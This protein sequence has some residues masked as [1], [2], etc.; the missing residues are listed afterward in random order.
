LKFIKTPLREGSVFQ[1]HP[2]SSF[3]QETRRV[4]KTLGTYLAIILAAFAFNLYRLHAQK[5]DDESDESETAMSEKPFFSLTTVRSYSRT[6]QARLWASYKGISALD[7]RVYRVS[8]PVKFFQQ[9]DDPHQVGEAEKDEVESDYRRGFSTLE[10]TRSVKS[11]IYAAVKEYVRDQLKRQHRETFNKK[12]RQD[13]TPQRTPLNVADY[14]RVPLLNPSQLV[15]SWR[16]KL[17]TV[18]SGYDARSISLGRREPGVYLVEGVSGDLRAYCVAIVTELAMVQ[19]TTTDGEVLTYI[20]DRQTGAPREGAH[21]LLTRQREILAK[22]LTDQGGIFKT[23]VERK[24]PEEQ[25]SQQQVETEENDT[26]ENSYL[27]MASDHDSFV[28]SDLDSFYFGAYGDGYDQSLSGYIYT[29]RPVYRPEQKV[30]FKGILRRWANQRYELV[31]G[32]SVKVTIDDYQGGKLSEQTLAL[33]SRGTFSG[34]LD[35]PAEAPLGTYH[36]SAQVGSGETTS[37]YFSVQEYKKP[38]YKVRVT[39][40]KQ[41]ASVGERVRFTID[42]RYFFG[43][44]VADADVKYYIH[45]S[46]YYNYWWGERD[47][48]DEEEDDSE[49]MDDE[50]YG[51]DESYYYGIGGDMVDEG[52]GKLDDKGRMTV[53]FEV[54][55]PDETDE[56]DYTYRLEAQV[57]DASR[58][59]MQASASFTGT[60]G[61][62]IAYAQ[63][64][65]YIYY[66]NDQAR[67]KIRTADYLGHPV[68]ARVTLK[69]IEHRW[70]KVEK[71]NGYGST[72]TDYEARERELSSADIETGAQGMADYD[73]AVPLTGNIYI[74]TILHEE[75]KEVANRGGSFW[76]TDR[77]GEWSELFFRDYGESSI[78]L[79]PDKKSYR[80]GETAHVLAVLP[81][82]GV[83]LLVTTE[84]A[85]VMTA[86]QLDA[87]GRTLLIDVPIESI[88]E[89]NV[90]LCVA[91]VK[92]DELYMDDQRLS[93]PARDKYL[94]L[95]II[96]NKKEYK[97]R[98]TASY[99]ILARNADGSA[100]QGAEVSLGVVDEAIYS[101]MAEN[102]GSIRQEFY[103]RR[104]KSVETSLSRTFLF[105][106]YSGKEAINLASNRS[107]YQLADF[108][109]E[110]TLTEPTVRREFK[111]TAFWQPDVVTGA[112]GR[113]TVKFK[114][115]DNLTTWR[116]TARA[117]TADTRVGSAVA[118]VVARKDVI[119]RLEM[120]RFLTEGD[121]VIISGVVHN[122]LKTQKTTRISLE[123][124]GAQLLD[125]K[126]QTVTIPAMGQHRVDW[127]VAARAAGEMSLLAKALTDTESDAVEMTME[128]V[129]HGLKQTMGQATTITEDMSEQTITLDLPA[130]PDVEARKL[131]IEASPS[132]A[133]T[134]F[135]ALDYLT[136]YPYGCVEQTMSRFLPDVIV[137]Q[138]LREVQTA[139]ITKTNNLD[140]KVQ[141]GLERLY[142][143]Q[144][145]DGGWGWWK[146]DESDPF[147]TAYVIDGLTLASRAGYKTETWRVEG[148]RERLRRLI[149]EG[150]TGRGDRLPDTETRA[151]MIYAL[152][153]SG[154]TDSG[155]VDE[156]YGTRENL[157]AYGR[158]LLALAL[159]ERGD[160]R[161]REV[162]AE[163]E[164]LARTNDFEAHW[165]TSFKTHYGYERV[166]DTEAT[167]LSLKALARITPE[168]PLLAKAARW[169][170]GNRRHGYYWLST[171]ETAFAIFG[172]TEYLKVSRELEPDYMLE[173]YVNDEPVI[174]RHITS[175]D[176]RT[177]QTFTVE[178]KGRAVGSTNRVRIVKRGRGALYLSS[179]LEYF[180]GDEE[181]AAQSSNDLKLTREYL[182]L[183]VT[184]NGNG[185][186]GWKLEPLSGEVRSGDLIVSR[187]RVEGARAQYLMV[188]DP[189]PAGC[190]QIA[191][192]SGINL[193]YVDGHWS[194]WYSA[195]EFRDARTV[196][197]L[198]YFD[199]DTTFQYA[200]RVEVPGSFRIAPARAEQ[201][202]QPTVQANTGNT[203]LNILDKK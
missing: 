50:G 81:D 27:V 145:A 21:V 5:V 153:E 166:M 117:V 152:N 28:I 75:G 58:R 92:N 110:T 174:S 201:M 157:Q 71:D 44:P 69:F 176:V 23:K 51:G 129:P 7:F 39:G 33:S 136:G 151:Y 80:P 30:Y 148:G 134:L 6:E 114:L 167:A 202:Y 111:D 100:A 199:G 158:A 107:S 197:F 159:F 155:Y 203:G 146:N 63:P 19:K 74:K 78:K 191:S 141:R 83:H 184:D 12:F 150:S 137:A 38:E 142:S 132:I 29:D 47:T 183:R 108:K 55:L 156:L 104:Y 170:V 171:R 95:E 24:K 53:D 97:P 4:L 73:Y 8:D 70:E 40:P 59:E 101:I 149:E 128:I 72:Y 41:F 68:A 187:L 126:T 194:D 86:R 169:L 154:E 162:A 17:S 116:A 52:E 164:T 1:L 161:A 98:D 3:D 43:S 192:V 89:P 103:G 46:R 138:A 76:A 195:R 90:Y 102:A 45:R 180:T 143:F 32:S 185:T 147:M 168:S 135:G 10:T 125:P 131:R 123:V 11:W 36:I 87:P 15:S 77:R 31:E 22:G 130:H 106:G 85:S 160:G 48:D 34:E 105:M 13:S 18:D 37:H 61:H 88:Y 193:S 182:R 2:R 112:D 190:V 115:P 26:R 57:T 165:Q 35:L 122:F 67:I 91:Y 172:L 66:Q 173:V 120:P 49:L 121:T 175:M 79:I 139:S 179:T 56:W 133:S 64:E 14:A 99:T 119:M 113:A 60:R 109:N 93:V 16:E 196:F 96:P 54:P 200:M 65:R 163:L 124:D 181:V 42:A 84:L 188:E 186:S 62:A 94:K 20:V 198:D 177:A 127:R 178:R 189:I 140:E 82:E 25:T 9:L 118:K 144:R